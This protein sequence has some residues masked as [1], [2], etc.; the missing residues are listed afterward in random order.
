[1]SV[2]YP[3]LWAWLSSDVTI[4]DVSRRGFGVSRVVLVSSEG[5]LQQAVAA[6]ASRT[7]VLPAKPVH[8]VTG[9]PAVTTA[10]AEVGRAPNGHVTDGTL[11]GQMFTDGALRPSS[12]TATVTT[13]NSKL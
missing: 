4:K 1:M 12:L 13:V 3:V 7:L 10:Q 9:V 5:A 2:V 8:H 11:E 6:T